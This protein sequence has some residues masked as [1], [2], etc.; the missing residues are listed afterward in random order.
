MNALISMA[1]KLMVSNS[2]SASECVTNSKFAISVARMH[3]EGGKTIA[4]AI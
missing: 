2:K 1:M 3:W 4:P